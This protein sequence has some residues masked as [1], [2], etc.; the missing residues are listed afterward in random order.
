MQGRIELIGCLGVGKTT[1]L[2][3]CQRQDL[4]LGLSFTFEDL[5]DLREER[6]F[7]QQKQDTRTFFIQTKY[8]LYA[9]D[10]IQSSQAS[11][12]IIVSDFSLLFHH[13]GYS[14]VL[15]EIGL[16]DSIEFRVLEQILARLQSQIP[17]LL[18]VVFCSATSRT[19]EQ[20]IQMRSRSTENSVSL[21]FINK[22]TYAATE[23]V[24]Q[25]GVPV[26]KLDL[27]GE[28]TSDTPIRLKQFVNTLISNAR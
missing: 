26:L 19:I 9:Y 24:K 3:S 5:E 16:L 7:W 10:L 2:K 17:K 21:E 1:Y 28:E 22:L 12:K 25:V 11:N 14:K 8:Y 18:G 6:A 20:R 15:K 4:G 13:Y 27:E 23:Y